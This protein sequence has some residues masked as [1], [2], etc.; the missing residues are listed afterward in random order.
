[1]DQD[2]RANH[3]V[4]RA[5]EDR[6]FNRTPMPQPSPPSPAAGVQDTIK[7]CSATAFRLAEARVKA[8]FTRDDT[9]VKKLEQQLKEPFGNCDPKWREV[10]EN[11]VHN[12]VAVQKNI[13]YR[14]YNKISDYVIEDALPA[15]ALVALLADWGTGEHGAKNML[16]RIADRKPDVVIH[17][18][19]VYYSGTEYEFQNYF[20]AVWQQTLGLPKLNWNT[21]A[22]GPLSKPATFTLAGNH[23]MYAGGAPYYMTIDLLGQPASY[24]CLRNKD[25]QFVALDTGLHDSNP[26]SAGSA[27]YLEDAEVKWLKDK[28]AT[29]NG[30]KTVLLSHHQL[31]TAY[32]EEEIE[33]KPVNPKLLP[34]VQDVLADIDVWFWGHE[35]NLVIFDE[36]LGVLARCIGHAAFPVPITQPLTRNSVPVKLTLVADP[37][38]AFFP[39]GYVMIQLDG[40]SATA[41]YWQ[42]DFETDNETQIFGENL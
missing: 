40:K 12:R 2:I 15:N 21:K 3:E 28:M 7:F 37:K 16:R 10:I 35:H 22:A 36:Y 23:D 30:R 14:P 11:Y 34:Q 38:E 1:M 29:K 24:F 13:P 4:V 27:T 6:E 33:S 9:E 31:F 19:D 42:Y 41:T 5:I 25:W 26:T 32:T 20:Y 39:H 18:G 8:F 17:L